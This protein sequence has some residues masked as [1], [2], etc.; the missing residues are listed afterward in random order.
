[1]TV[2]HAVASRLPPGWREVAGSK[3]D[4]E[5]RKQERE[6]I[7]CPPQRDDKGYAYSG[8]RP[9]DVG[10]NKLYTPLIL[11]HAAPFAVTRWTNLYFP[12]KL[13]LF[14]DFVGG[15]LAPELGHGIKDVAVTTSTWKGLASSTLA[16]HTCYWCPGDAPAADSPAQHQ[17][18][19]I[20][21]LATLKEA[22]DLSSWR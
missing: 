13:G 6:L 16:A 3:A 1:V 18:G 7:T 10:Q 5:T 20:T 15:P 2:R 8:P 4:F 19:R 22:L 11:H 17:A 9:Y 14:G 21:A 12:S